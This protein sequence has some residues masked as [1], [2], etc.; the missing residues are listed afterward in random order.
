VR[1]QSEARAH[2]IGQNKSLQII[3][4]VAR[5]TVDTEIVAAL[6]AKQDLAAQ[7]TGDARAIA[8]LIRG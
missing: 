2:R 1:N 3:D 8:K 7:V 6:A 4:L 5:D